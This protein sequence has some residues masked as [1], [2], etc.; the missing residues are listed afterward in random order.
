MFGTAATQR[1]RALQPPFMIS[2]NSSA[3]VEGSTVT[4][5]SSGA[6][7]ATAVVQSEMTSATD[8]DPTNA[9][10]SAPP[11]AVKR[12]SVMMSSRY[13]DYCRHVADCRHRRPAGQKNEK[14]GRSLQTISSQLIPIF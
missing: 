6:G 8:G 3:V 11:A 7:G 5:F 12:E 9:S 2:R 4:S 14:A 13:A 1:G 10:R